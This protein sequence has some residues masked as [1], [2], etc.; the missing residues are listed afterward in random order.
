LSTELSRKLRHKATPPERAMW[1][2]LR[3]LRRN[4]VHFRRQ[5][6]IGS[7]YADFACHQPG[8]VIEVDGGTHGTDVAQSNDAS[9]DDYFRGRGYRVL[10]FWNGDVLRNPS[11]VLRVVEDE[12]TQISE[13]GPQ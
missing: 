1:A 9:R 3:D 6:H 13:R 5:V 12:L 8:L 7:Y 10:R 2:I 4:G 11:G